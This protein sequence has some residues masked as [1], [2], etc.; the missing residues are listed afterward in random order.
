MYKNLNFGQKLKKKINLKKPSKRISLQ[1]IK[2][3][4]FFK[5]VKWNE[6]LE[7]K[8]VPPLKIDQNA[9]E[10]EKIDSTLKNEH[11]Y[12]NFNHEGKSGDLETDDEDL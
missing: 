11:F 7:K 1:K 10:H 12:K 9:V 4:E 2:D 3:H 8:I 6:Y 5:N